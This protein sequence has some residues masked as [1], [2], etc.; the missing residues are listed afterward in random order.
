MHHHEC[1]GL[2]RSSLNLALEV[3]LW[4]RFHLR[5]RPLHI[6]CLYGP[7]PRL[8]GRLRGGWVGKSE[9]S[10]HYELGRCGYLSICDAV[11]DNSLYSGII[12]E[13]VAAETLT[14]LAKE[15]V[16]H[17]AGCILVAK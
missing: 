15:H 13:P 16:G 14:V 12:F 3:S 11:G 8:R 9:Y 4:S 2:A 17:A 6:H 7:L 10:V 5:A 1:N